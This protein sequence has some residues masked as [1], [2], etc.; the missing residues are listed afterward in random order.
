M[1]E[2]EERDAKA[3]SDRGGSQGNDSR[4]RATLASLGGYVG[5]DWLDVAP[6]LEDFP[7]KLHSRNFLR[8][9][10]SSS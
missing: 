10:F 4:G 3:L 6:R 5:V 9:L 1:F 2:G 8:V 7:L